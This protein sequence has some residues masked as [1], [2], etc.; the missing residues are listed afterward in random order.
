MFAIFFQ[1]PEYL[2]KEWS[3]RKEIVEDPDEFSVWTFASYDSPTKMMLDLGMHTLNK[4]GS[5]VMSLYCPFWMLNKTGLMIGYRVNT[6][7]FIPISK[8]QFYFGGI[9]LISV[10][11]ILLA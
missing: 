3:C 11:G 6:L 5:F 7:L 10:L 9:K 1:L 8:E 2:E 4:N